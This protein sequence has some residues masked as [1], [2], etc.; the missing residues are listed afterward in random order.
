MRAYGKSCPNAVEVEQSIL[1]IPLYPSLDERGLSYV[2]QTIKD[3]FEKKK[4]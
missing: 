4:Q 2:C 3:I 1:H